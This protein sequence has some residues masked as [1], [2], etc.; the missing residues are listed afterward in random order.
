[1]KQL[2]IPILPELLFFLILACHLVGVLLLG[3]IGRLLRRWYQAWTAVSTDAR[4]V[5]GPLSPVPVEHPPWVRPERRS[6]PPQRPRQPDEPP[7]PTLVHYGFDPWLDDN[8]VTPPG[9]RPDGL[10][11]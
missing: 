8:R 7:Q 9:Q 3:W 10:D 2:L 4:D 11:P 5:P 6:A 1:M